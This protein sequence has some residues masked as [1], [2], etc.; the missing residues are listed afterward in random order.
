MEKD[1]KQNPHDKVFTRVFS[2]K[3]NAVNLLRNIL[4][5]QI[6]KHLS[7]DEM[8]FEKESFVSKDLRDYY[9]DLLVNVP[10]VNT[11]CDTRVYF[12]FEHKSM[13]F[14]NTPL[15]MLRYMLEIWDH[16]GKVYESRG[17]LPVIVPVLVT[18]AASGW[19]GRTL[20]D[21][22]DLPSEGFRSF[23]PDFRYT[24]YDTVK[25]DPESYDFN[26]QIKALLTIW[27]L[28]YSDEFMQDLFR[29]FRLIKQIEPQADLHDFLV[30]VIQYLFAIRKEEDHVEIKNIAGRE[31]LERGENMGTIEEM[32]IRKGEER[33]EQRF[34]KEKEKLVAVYGQQGALKAAQEML[35]EALGERFGT[36]NQALIE[37]IKNVQSVDTL[38]MLFKQCFR[39]DSLEAFEE[40]VHRAIK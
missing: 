8:Y 18:H 23:V 36:V 39:V 26:T 37:K 32:L 9:S 30:T 10:A 12:L 29:V 34:A 13:H 22:V 40:Q 17:K 25:E 16:Y 19:K 5:E 27:R 11:D 2:V 20:A 14:S 3:Q 31:L 24:L 35:L 6:Q 28:S 15:Q 38:K 1:N 7:L 4:P 21:L 33:A